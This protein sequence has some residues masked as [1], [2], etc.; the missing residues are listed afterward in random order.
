MFFNILNSQLSYYD[1]Q[2]YHDTNRD[3]LD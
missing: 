2:L 1:K 3:K